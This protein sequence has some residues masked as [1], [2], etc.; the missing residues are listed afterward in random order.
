[1]MHIIYFLSF[2]FLFLD[3]EAMFP[4]TIPTSKFGHLVVEMNT[5]VINLE[6]CNQSCDDA[7][8]LWAILF[9]DLNPNLTCPQVWYTEIKLI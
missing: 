8:H 5:R 6:G 9:T 1:M 7:Y 3:N 4:S 2:S